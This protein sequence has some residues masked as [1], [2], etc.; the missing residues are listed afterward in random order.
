[1]FVLSRLV[2]FLVTWWSISVRVLVSPGWRRL[3]TFV[4]VVR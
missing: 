4:V 2:R 3:F 1:M